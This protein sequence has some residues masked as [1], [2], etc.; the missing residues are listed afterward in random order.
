VLA[1]EIVTIK[2]GLMATSMSFRTISG[3]Q[4][5]GIDPQMSKN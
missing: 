5:S 4:D 2:P 1:V 3:L